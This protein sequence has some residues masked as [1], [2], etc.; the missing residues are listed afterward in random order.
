MG[1]GESSATAPMDVDLA[2]SPPPPPIAVAVRRRSLTPPETVVVL[3][4]Q[5]G[6]MALGPAPATPAA[7]TDPATA[8]PAYCGARRGR[9]I[10]ALGLAALW[11]GRCLDPARQPRHGGLKATGNGWWDRRGRLNPS[12]RRLPTGAVRVRKTLSAPIL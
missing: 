8:R 12:R 6:L 11:C 3:L 5:E 10:A 7:G 9:P 4:Q 1:E 2:A